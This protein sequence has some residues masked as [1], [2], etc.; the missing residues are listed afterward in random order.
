M[1]IQ[2][3]G[4]VLSLSVYS[5]D[6][7]NPEAVCSTQGQL[8]RHLDMNSLGSASTGILSL[9]CILARSFT[10]SHLAKSRL[11]FPPAWFCF[12]VM[13][14][15]ALKKSMLKEGMPLFWRVSLDD[16]ILWNSMP[17]KSPSMEDSCL[18]PARFFLFLFFGF[19][20]CC[21]THWAHWGVMPKLVFLR[22]KTPRCI[23]LEG[24][25][26]LL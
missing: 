10:H 2:D 16:K 19:Y 25:K 7:E 8:L 14:N 9:S 6:S 24:K 20:W 21:C 11:G 18:W 17:L 26:D 1:R 23:I 4:K 22:L 5:C 3:Y 13:A 15:F 12:T